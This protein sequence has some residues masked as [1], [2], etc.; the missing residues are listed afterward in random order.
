MRVR[1][2]RATAA[3]GVLGTSGLLAGCLIVLGVVGA[4]AETS[5]FLVGAFAIAFPSGI[6]LGSWRARKLYWCAAP[7]AHAIRTRGGFA[8]GLAFPAYVVV[9]V[10]GTGL[11]S[12]TFEPRAG[13]TL[14]ASATGI[15]AVLPA[16]VAAHLI[17]WLTAT[18]VER[19]WP[20]RLLE[21]RGG[22]TD[23]TH[24][25]AVP[26]EN[27]AHDAVNPPP[28]PAD[29]PQPERPAPH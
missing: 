26:V 29:W 4:S 2:V 14:A 27:T 18:D 23:T 24:V 9:L 12:A 6:A 19:R 28:P 15:A 10:A 5:W 22:W 21:G 13:A 20:V 17:V 1:S 3:G 8:R 25:Y 7:P 16:L 11:F